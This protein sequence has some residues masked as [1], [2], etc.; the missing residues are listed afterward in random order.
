M[1]KASKQGYTALAITDTNVLYGYP[2]FY[3]ACVSAN[4]KPI[5][6]MT[7]Y[8]T[9]GLSSVEAVLYALNNEGLTAMYQLSSAIKMKDKSLVPFEWITKYQSNI[10]I[11][12]KQVEQKHG[13]ILEK[14]L[15]DEF[16]YVNSDS[17]MILD[18][19]ESGYE[20]HVI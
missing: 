7:V 2:K 19:H 1:A 10:A 9:D 20:L 3:D 8:I 16:I 6:G 11:V 13:H 17:K 15:N 4:I 12:F 14:F 18:C 5:F